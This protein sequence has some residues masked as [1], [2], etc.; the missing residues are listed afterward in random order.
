MRRPRDLCVSPLGPEAAHR[1]L[2]M[3]PELSP[4]LLLHALGTVMAPSAILSIQ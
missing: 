4:G 1:A 3:E 2:R